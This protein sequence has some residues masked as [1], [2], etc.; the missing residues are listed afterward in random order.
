MYI[1][2]RDT[3]KIIKASEGQKLAF[4]GSSSG[5]FFTIIT[6]P[7]NFKEEEDLIEVQDTSIATYIPKY[8]PETYNMTV[9]EIQQYIISQTKILLQEFLHENPLYY[10]GKYYNVSSEAQSHLASLI[11]AAEDAE[12]LDILFIPMWNAVGENREIFELKELKILMIEI[13][14]YILP[15]I[16]QQQNLENKIL[17]IS[18]KEE[19]LT[20]NL[21][22]QKVD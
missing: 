3:I 18:N 12:A 13:Q 11:K 5:D 2:I 22:Y 4:R 1:D 17:S 9:D 16:I 10:K 14:K 20:L 21:A 8:E 19:L 15:Y 6:V 7:L